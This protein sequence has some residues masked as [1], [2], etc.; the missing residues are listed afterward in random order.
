MK[1][2]NTFE[3][4]KA[5][6]TEYLV[7]NQY[8]RTP[9]RYAILEHINAIDGHFT[10]EML[11][12]TMQNNFRVSLA[13]VYNSLDLLI[14]MGLIIRHQFGNNPAE[15]ERTFRTIIHHH[16]VCSNCG[17]IKEFTDKNLK[18]TIEAKKFNNFLPHH[19]SLCIYGYCNKCKHLI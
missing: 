4:V 9:E 12:K 19:F 16:L 13:S 10:A 18:T 7:K 8:R 17:K 3:T 1:D 11:F 14:K 2:A 6:F 15:Y 5:G